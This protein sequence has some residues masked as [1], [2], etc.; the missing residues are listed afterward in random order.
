MEGALVQNIP[1]EK[2]NTAMTLAKPVT[3]ESGVALVGAGLKL[4]GPL[5]DYLKNA[6]VTQI[7]VEG[8]PLADMDGGLDLA[9]L[10]GRLDHLFRRYKQ[11]P[12]MWV[13]R[14]TIAQY[15]TERL[16]AQAAENPQPPV[17]VEQ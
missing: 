10:L 14:N 5:L 7:T 9:A 8:C 3:R 2:A 1:I 6:G 16:E 4:T 11:D 12:L 15:L 13:L 17:Q